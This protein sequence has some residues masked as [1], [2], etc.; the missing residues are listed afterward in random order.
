MQAIVQATQ[1]L[2]RLEEI[3]VSI[4]IKK[5]GVREVTDAVTAKSNQI[6]ELRRTTGDVTT[7]AQR[8]IDGQRMVVPTMSV[9][10]Q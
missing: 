8:G 2:P 7:G 6:A 10:N 3:E 5:Q 4:R 9:N 1:D